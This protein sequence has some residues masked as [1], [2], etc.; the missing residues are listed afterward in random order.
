MV[1]GVRCTWPDTFDFLQLK[2]LCAYRR[3][4]LRIPG[5]QNLLVTRWTVAST[6]GWATPWRATTADSQNAA[7][8]RGRNVPVEMSPNSSTP[9][10]DLDVM[11]SDLLSHIRLQSAQPGW[12]AAMAA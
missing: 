12:S 7:G 11:K 9:A 8:T 3:T 5:Q 1:A 6:P 2:H 10:N 4:Y